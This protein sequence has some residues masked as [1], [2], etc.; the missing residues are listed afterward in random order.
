M[1]ERITNINQLKAGDKII[2]IKG[3]RYEIL[4]FV[5][6]HPHNDKYSV[7]LDINYDGVPKFYNPTLDTSKWYR[8]TGSES[9]WAEIHK[10]LA[11]NLREGCAYH[12]ERYE[13]FLKQISSNGKH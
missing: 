6:I 8:Y 4:E 2:N 1:M 7:M 12:E 10:I 11:E 9:Q 13:A 3:D 5:C